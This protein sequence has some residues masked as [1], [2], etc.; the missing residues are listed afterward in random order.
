[1]F[2]LNQ[3]VKLNP[4][5][6]GSEDHYF[7]AENNYG[8]IRSFESSCSSEGVI[9]YTYTVYFPEIQA[10]VDML[11][12]EMV[13]FDMPRKKKEPLTYKQAFKILK[14]NEANNV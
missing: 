8:I 14:E 9:S 7:L 12:E 11:E 4:N 5:Y 3:K 6:L 10:T 1:M 13:P 2:D